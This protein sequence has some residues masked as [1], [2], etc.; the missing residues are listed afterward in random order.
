[1]LGLLLFLQYLAFSL[2]GWAGVGVATPVLLAIFA[3]AS[4]DGRLIDRERL[5]TLL[6]P[7]AHQILGELLLFMRRRPERS[8]I[9]SAPKAITRAHTRWLF[10]SAPLS[11]NVNHSI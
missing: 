7:V 6:D 4:Q 5:A 10:G 3:L 1:M 9:S 8:K 2:R 11:I